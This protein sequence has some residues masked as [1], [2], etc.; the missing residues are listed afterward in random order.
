MRWLLTLSCLGVL[1]FSAAGWGDMIP[2]KLNCLRDLNNQL[3]CFGINGKLFTVLNASV[4][5]K[6]GKRKEFTLQS[7]SAT[8]I[9]HHAANEMKIRY[10]NAK[11]W[12]IFKSLSPKTIPFLA[13]HNWQQPNPNQYVCATLPHCPYTQE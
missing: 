13:N 1:L 6:P 2:A 12:L 3:T 5:L 4:N 11:D 10:I 8:Y 9:P 7:A